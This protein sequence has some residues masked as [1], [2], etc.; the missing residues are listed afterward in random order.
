MHT[1]HWPVSGTVEASSASARP[2]MRKPRARFRTTSEVDRTS[3][4]HATCSFVRLWEHKANQTNT[5]IYMRVWTL[6]AQ[7]TRLYSTR[8]A[9][10]ASLK[11]TP[12]AANMGVTPEFTI[13]Y[14]RN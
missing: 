5:D 10:S 12:N 6:V 3:S 8:P 4:D 11:A 7:S 14:D 2:C 9:I 1:V 13:T